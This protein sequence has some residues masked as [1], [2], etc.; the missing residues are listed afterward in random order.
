MTTI[1]SAAA[2]L[3]SATAS[4]VGSVV[5]GVGN[6]MKLSHVITLDVNANI[7]GI[8]P[9]GTGCLVGTDPTKRLSVGDGGRPAFI[10]K[11]LVY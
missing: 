11:A 4:W 7:G 6:I 5:P 10:A 3:L 1:E 2:G 9:T 8:D